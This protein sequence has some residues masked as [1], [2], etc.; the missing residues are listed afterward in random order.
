MLLAGACG[1]AEK[2][3]LAVADSSRD[4][5]LAPV[6]T[7]AVL[8][9]VGPDTIAPPAPVETVFVEKPAP[10]PVSKPTPV[11]STAG[12]AT[13]PKPAPAAVPRTLASGT[14]FAGTIQDS[15]DSKTSK[16]GDVVTIRVREDVKDSTGRTVIPAGAT[17]RAEITE[18]KWSENKS[19]KGTLRMSATSV[20][21][22]GK[23][24]TLAG[25]VSR[26]EFLYR[27]RGGAVGDASKVAGGAAA[28][29]VVGGL[30]GKGTGAVIGGVLGGAVGTQRAVETKDRDIIVKP[31]SV[32]TVT[33]KEELTR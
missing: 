24:T 26:P 9:D 3:Q 25:S 8:A 13:A 10:P 15:I 29:A 19:D 2:G 14:K 27:K 18:I 22:E 20:A 17:V 1:K 16:V 31:G 33:L 28:G 4:L 7:T 30:L 5:Q 6:D 23:R 32:V 11:P 21:V 12:A